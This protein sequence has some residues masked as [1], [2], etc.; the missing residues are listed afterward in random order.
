MLPVAAA[1]QSMQSTTFTNYPFK[2]Q[3]W[4]DSNAWAHRQAAGLDP[5]LSH[6]SLHLVLHGPPH[7]GHLSLQPNQQL[8]IIFSKHWY[9]SEADELHA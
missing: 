9:G 2:G 6:G 4:C 3:R 8:S 7:L 5:V 1:E